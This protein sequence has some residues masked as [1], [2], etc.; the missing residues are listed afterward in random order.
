MTSSCFSRLGGDFSILDPS[1]RDRVGG[2]GGCCVF[3]FG[4]SGWGFDGGALQVG[5]GSAGGLG[6]RWGLVVVGSVVIVEVFW[7]WGCGGWWGWR[8]GLRIWR[9][10]R[11]VWVEEGAMVFCGG[12]RW[13]WVARWRWVVFGGFSPIPVLGLSLVA[14][15]GASG[16]WA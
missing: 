2:G 4:G 1:S 3:L 16:L 5:W 9:G 11:L 14:L 10:D 15:L 8:W 7:R 12:G 13:F 6:L